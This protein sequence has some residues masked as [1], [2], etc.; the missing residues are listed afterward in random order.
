MET[1]FN[2]IYEQVSVTIDYDNGKLGLNAYHSGP[3][4]YFWE[5]ECPSEGCNGPYDIKEDMMEAI[6]SVNGIVEFDYTI[7]RKVK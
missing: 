2:L 1:D 7:V 5:T 4:W 6:T 3:G